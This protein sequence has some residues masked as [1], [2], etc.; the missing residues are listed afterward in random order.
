MGRASRAKK[1]R[2]HGQHPEEGLIAV[3]FVFDGKKYENFHQMTA[4]EM[5]HMK[6]LCR[7][8]GDLA[9]D[10]MIWRTAIR[11]TGM[12][13]ENIMA[14]AALDYIKKNYK[15][16]VLTGIAVE[17]AKLV[18]NSIGLEMTHDSSN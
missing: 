9:A 16:P 3:S 2:T 14:R 1:Q 7:D 17:D 4:S 6:D 5:K 11:G 18:Q 10:Q 8:H 13:A 15:G 12:V